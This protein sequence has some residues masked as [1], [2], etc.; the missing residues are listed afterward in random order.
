MATLKSTRE[1]YGETLVEL[2]EKYPNIVV[3]DADLASSTYTNKFAKVFPERF[4][5]CGVAE[6][7]MMGTAAG[8]A[9]S[10]K[11]PFASSFAIFATGRVYNQIRNTIACANLNVKICASHAG[12]TVGEDGLS[13]HCF[14]DIDLM[15][16]IPNMKIIVPC[17]AVET[18]EA[19][20]KVVNI[21]GPVYVRLGRPSIPIILDE[22]YKF[23][24]GKGVTLRE[25]NDVTLI[26]TGIMVHNCLKAAKQ[27]SSSG[28]EARVINIHTIKPID[29]EII[30][31]AARETRR[32]ITCEEHSIIGGL[33][34]AVAEVISENYPVHLRRIGIR[35]VFTTSG[36]PEILLKAYGLDIESIVQTVLKLVKS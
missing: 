13:H 36:K 18:R 27:L 24:F 33:G 19:I 1:A 31:K 16:V 20:K 29:Q 26:G 15:R 8:L 3:L 22:D 30:I 4:F 7:S 6:A 11:I 23:T 34:S 14:E 2:G 21:P 28:I 10:G 9:I 12:L 35:D 5:N 25:G 32:I 17:D